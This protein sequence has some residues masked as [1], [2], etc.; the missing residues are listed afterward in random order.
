MWK[1][2]IGEK[3]VCK[4][5]DREKAAVYDTNAIRIYKELNTYEGRQV[6]L[7]GHLP[8]EI[9]FLMNSFSKLLV[10]RTP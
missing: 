7:V 2:E 3:L 9:S 5:D 10:K 4:K 6:I 8:V 1:P